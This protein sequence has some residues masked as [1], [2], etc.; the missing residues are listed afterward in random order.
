MN[1]G[2]RIR[3]FFGSFMAGGSGAYGHTTDTRYRRDTAYTRSRP[4][5]EDR[6]IGAGGRR[7]LILESR[8]QV[9]TNAIVAGLIDRFQNYTVGPHGIN[10][11]A[12]T[13]DQ[14][15]NRAA[16]QYFAEWCKVAD[17]RG[18]TDFKG[19]LKS[20]EASTFDNGECFFVLT[21]N[22]RLQPIEA[23]RIATP[24]DL[25]SDKR[26]I[27]GCKVS[28]DGLILGYYVFTREDSGSINAGSGNWEFVD[29]RDMIHFVAPGFRFDQVRGTPRIAA[30][31]NT[32]RDFREFQDSTL[33]TAKH[34][35]KLS[36]AIKTEAGQARGAG[37]RDATPDT[38]ENKQKQ[39][40]F[41]DIAVFNLATNETLQ[42]LAPATPGPQF[43]G[44]SLHVLREFGAR[45]GIPYEMLML[46]FQKGSFAQSKAALLSFYRTIESD[47]CALRDMICQRV[48]NWIIA[49]AIKR[50]DLAPAPIDERT[51]FSTWYKVVWQFPGHEWIQ[52][53]EVIAAERDEYRLGKKSLASITN[54]TGKDWEDVL[55]DK[56]REINRA[57]EIVV[58]NKLDRFGLTWRDL[59]DAST[60]SQRPME[61]AA[62]VEP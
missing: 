7:K 19:L 62:K 30:C 14:E 5:D 12:K 36:V 47:Q 61:P 6:N 57:Q 8:D 18:R 9:R 56:A 1:I 24:S 16:E 49:R 4:V 17:Y 33:L 48:W 39:E 44:F 43:E 59:I 3:N 20:A 40:Y 53:G 10:P 21:D 22:G 37:A 28:D 35:A 26:I 46:D 2:N 34:Q 55:D 60:N 54:T 41:G 13:R 32:L 23:E 42:P 29:S 38:T 51:G 45:F 25:V 27:D 15:W 50:G 31:L 52:P 11:Q 58:A